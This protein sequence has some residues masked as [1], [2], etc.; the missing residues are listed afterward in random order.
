ME[1]KTGCTVC[2]KSLAY[3]VIE[4]SFICYCCGN[5]FTAQVQCENGHFVC[6]SCHQ[7]NANDYIY[8]YC[9]N[10]KHTDPV[11]IVN[12]IM[13]HSTV[14][15][16][17]PEHHFLVPAALLASYYNLQSDFVAKEKSVKIARER[18]EKVPGGF[19]GLHGA[20]GAGIG[21]GI[22]ISI[23]TGSTPLAAEEWKLSNLMTARSLDIIAR[24]GGPRCCKRDTFIAIRSAAEFLEELLR[25]VLPINPDIICHFVE[26]NKECLKENC[27][28]YQSSSDLDK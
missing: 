23:I 4:E 17:G 28:F 26:H 21:T 12:E 2:G 8:S 25:V 18:A 10:T 27:A 1:H 5:E 22:F 6:D 3:T 14:K 11:L 13:H 7:S 16:H 15:M 9:L 19:C 24:S 20:C